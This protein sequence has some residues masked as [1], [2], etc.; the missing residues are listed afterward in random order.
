VIASLRASQE[1]FSTS[2]TVQQIP[3]IC[4]AK[5]MNKTG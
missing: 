4:N 3:V 2:I 1:T 5:Y